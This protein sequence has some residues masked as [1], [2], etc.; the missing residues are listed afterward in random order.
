MPITTLEEL[1]TDELKDLHSA[2]TQLTKALPKMAKA[3]QSDD[4]R[5]AFQDHLKQTEG[6]VQRIEQACE[7]LEVKPRGKKCVAMEGLI[8]EGKELLTEEVDPSVL[9][10]GLIAA[11]QKVEHYEMA[12]YGTVVAHAKQLGYMEVADLLHKTFDEEK[13]ADEKLS[14]IAETMVNVEAASQ[15]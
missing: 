13:A 11:A 12:A 15:H 3:A 8:E 14:H 1:L 4:L 5:T 2:E 9:D 7:K 10:A 6:H